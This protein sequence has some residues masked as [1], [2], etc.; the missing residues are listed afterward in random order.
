M[1]QHSLTLVS[2][3]KHFGG[4][5]TK[6]SHLSPTTQCVM[7]FN[8]FLPEEA[9]ENKTKVPV[10][11]C[12]GGLTATEDNFA[13]KSGFGPRAAQY[14][15][16]LVF[17]DNS[18]R[19]VRFEAAGANP[20]I[21][22]SAGFYLNA[23]KDPWDKNW[24]MYDYVTKEL[25][26]VLAENLP[27]GGHGALTIFLKNQSNFKSVSAF[28]PICHPSKSSWGLFAFPQYLGE[29]RSTWEEYDTIELLK[30]YKHNDEFR[31]DVKV[32]IDQGTGD[33]FLNPD[34]LH[35]SVLIE[36]VKTLGLENQFVIRHHEGYNHG[37]YFISTFVN[38]HI[39]HHAAALGLTLRL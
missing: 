31:S 32:L 11:Y 1:T 8:V 7:V 35:T 36:T 16:A 23:T 38:D 37:Y 34:R 20:D 13:Q 21:G 24:K 9:V 28:A 17:P 3:N 18:P 30:R 2:K 29:D 39:D 33:E 5:L 10:L 4:T 26:A 22:Y 6:Y 27:I 12:L 14:G 15:L 19:N 25:P